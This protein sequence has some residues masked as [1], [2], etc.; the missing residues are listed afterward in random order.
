MPALLEQLSKLRAN[1][2]ILVDGGSHDGSLAFAKAH[3]S[4]KNSNWHILSAP[5]GR[6]SQL[7]CGAQWARSDWLIFL[8]ADSQLPNNFSNALLEADHTESDWGRFDIVF[9]HVSDST[10]FFNTMM[11]VIARFMNVRS[12]MSGIATG[13][14]AMFVR[15]SLFKSIGGY[16]PLPLME[17]V[18][19]SKRLK[20]H[21]RPLCT[22]LK[23]AG[24]SRR[25]QRRGLL[26]TIVKMWWFRLAF[27]LGVSAPRL[28]RRY[29]DAR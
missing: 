28:A 14:Q 1:E 2:V 7:N 5:R 25:W 8:H 15:R 23:V 10:D 18:A 12:R 3:H 26:T 29:D 24:N 6:A 13:D 22:R 27:F 11:K 16:P 9:E 19:L 17:D 4:A 21:S 20:K